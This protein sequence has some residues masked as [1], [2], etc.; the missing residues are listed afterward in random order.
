MLTVELGDLPPTFRHAL[1]KRN[2]DALVI[3]YPLAMMVKDGMPMVFPV[4]LIS[5]SVSRTGFVLKVTPQSADVVLNPDWIHQTGCGTAVSAK[6]LAKQF[7]A[8]GGLAFDEFRDR[9][10]D[11]MA[12]QLA[13]P[14]APDNLVG[15][16][17]PG[18]S[19]IHNAAAI[20]FPTETGFT[21]ETAA[22]LGRLA[23]MSASELKGTALWNLLHDNAAEEPA[24]TVLNPMPLTPNQLEATELAMAGAVTAVTGPSGTGKSQVI[25]SIIASALAADKTVLFASRNHQAID[26][27]EERLAELA[28]E[29]PIMV[30]ANDREGDRDTDFVRVIADLAGDDARPFAKTIGDSLHRLRDKARARTRAVRDRAAAQHLHRALSEHIERR[31]GILARVGERRPRSDSLFSG[32]LRLLRLRRGAPA[33]E[34][35]APGATLDELDTAIRRDQKALARI[36]AAK[37]PTPLGEE[38]VAGMNKLFPAL[39]AN[40]LAVDAEDRQKLHAEHKAFELSGRIN[41]HEMTDYVALLVLACRPIWAATTLCVPSRVPL[42]PGIFD[43][44]IFDEASQCDIACALPLMAR[45]K[46]AVIVGDPN[47][48]ES[49]PGLGLAQER[50][51]MKAAGLPLRGMGRYA[52]SRNSLFGFCASRPGTRSVMLRDQFRCA[53]AIIDYLNDAFYEGQLRA[54]RGD[55]GLKVPA[56][57]KPGISW[58]DVRGRV[59]LDQAGQSQNHEEAKAIAAHL[60]VLLCEQDYQGSIGVISPFNAQAAL[61]K[62]LIE[63]DIPRELRE[64]A[65]IRVGTADKFQSEERDVILF[66]PVA[67]PGLGQDA[68]AFLMGD[69][70]RFNV[71][72]SRARALAHVFGNLSF[73]RESGIGHLAILADKAS[74]LPVRENSED[75]FGSI[76]ERRIDTALRARG[77]DPTP[78]YPIAGRCLDFALFGKGEVKLGLEVDGWRWHMDPDDRRR[79]DDMRRDYQLKSMGW[80]VRRFWVH[81]LEQDMER[82]LDQV[83]RDLAR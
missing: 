58:T 9:L 33:A 35:L 64:H 75:V 49:V 69:K 27:V 52:Q 63:N 83:E 42:A 24:G 13:G 70:R 50:T 66:S 16:I 71:A 79:I 28:P 80:R 20:F 51:L 55:A 5:A 73:A 1:S 56:A 17:D 19:G 81:E 77:H 74:N 37:D 32:L 76:W 67:G 7:D 15:S 3:G 44:V 59:S 82:C 65:E 54:A 57:A 43:Y 45:A 62:R 41:A 6:A 53:P 10:S 12:T 46:R 26:A 8:A 48:P 38:I 60:G 2:G 40:A 11:C 29:Q 31:D 34:I 36:I 25:V 22:D 23:R 47:Q 18:A 61:L 72:I 78:Q 39:T 68:R 14:L 4:G 21:A 30:R